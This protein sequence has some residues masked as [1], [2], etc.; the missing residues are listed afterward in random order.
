LD[1][2]GQGTIDLIL[3]SKITRLGSMAFSYVMGDTGTNIMNIY[4]GDQ[5]NKSNLD[6]LLQHSN[7]DNYE[8]F[9]FNYPL[10]GALQF[11]T[12]VYTSWDQDIGGHK[13]PHWL[14]SDKRKDP[15]VGDWELYTTEGVKTL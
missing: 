7:A 11:H 6:V 10:I 12:N 3:S 8:C 1:F 15:P 4:I 14:G 2:N 13:L 5:N 9:K